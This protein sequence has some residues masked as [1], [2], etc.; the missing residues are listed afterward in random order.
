MSKIQGIKRQGSIVFFVY[1]PKAE[2][3]HAGFQKGDEVLIE[4]TSKGRLEVTRQ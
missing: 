3:E 4:C 2:M 1:I